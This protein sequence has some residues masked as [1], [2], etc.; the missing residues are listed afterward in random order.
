M[1]EWDGMGVKGSVWGGRYGTNMDGLG[2]VMG[3]LG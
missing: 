3:R 2:W 1:W